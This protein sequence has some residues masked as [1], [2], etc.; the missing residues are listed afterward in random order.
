MLEEVFASSNCTRTNS[1]HKAYSSLSG[2]TKEASNEVS[3]QRQRVLLGS[4][5]LIVVA[6][7]DI[8]L[9]SEKGCH[10]LQASG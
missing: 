1:S 3:D 2:Y 9:T 6:M 4:S 10:E 7:V 8:V 5:S